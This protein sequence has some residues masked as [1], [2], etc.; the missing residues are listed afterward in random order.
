MNDSKSEQRGHV[1]PK[2][3]EYSDAVKGKEF[4]VPRKTPFVTN[5]VTAKNIEEEY[6]EFKENPSSE[7]ASSLLSAAIIIDDKPLAEDMARY[8]KDKQ[9]VDQATLDL[10]DKIL[11]PPPS[12]DARTKIDRIN[13]RIATLKNRT[14]KFPRSAIPWIEMARLYTIK[15]QH[16]KARRSA[17]IALNLAPFD[18]YVVRCAVR[19][20]LHIHDFE[21]ACNYIRRATAGRF[22][23]WLKATEVN[24]ALIAEKGTPSLKGHLPKDVSGIDIFHFSELFESSGIL[25]LNA[26]NRRAANKR[27]G[28]AW[29][30]PSDAVI[31]HAEWVLRNRLPGLRDKVDIDFKRS[32]EALT[33]IYYEDL[34][35]DEALNTTREWEL[36]EPYSKYP[37]IVGVSIASNAGYYD[38][39]AEIGYRGLMANPASLMLNNNLCYTLLRAGR[40]DEAEKI[41]VKMNAIGD[42]SNDL[43]FSATK[44]L[45]EFKR[46]RFDIGRRAYNE[47]MERCRRNNDLRLFLKAYL[48]LA[49][50]EIESSTSEAEKTSRIALSL[51]EGTKY[52]D[53]VLLRK[54]IMDK[55]PKKTKR[56]KTPSG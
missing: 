51:S 23:P 28:V 8:L 3:L 15:G 10:A 32:L 41:I 12:L 46:S 26:G 22:D 49:L 37:Y 13:L 27:F 34:K 53:I 18:R 20:F 55:L 33:W 52:P 31:T 48:N 19:F 1:V 5:E 2:W 47:V 7:I 25:E 16:Q 54:E 45:F 42:A 39:A 30:N 4:I 43:C 9:N 40:I 36:Q 44:G 14:V 24:V 21:A 38:E 6:K 11:N 56:L 29:R 17:L 50:A 35:L